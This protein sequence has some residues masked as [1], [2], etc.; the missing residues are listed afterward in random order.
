MTGEVRGMPTTP[1]LLG[2][3]AGSAI[4]R[5]LGEELRRTRE[6][7]GWSRGHLVRQLPSGIGDRTL[8]S[9]E[10]GARQ[11][12]VLRL[13]ELAQTLGVPASVLVSDALQRARLHLHNVV[14][15][16]DLRQLLQDDNINY[17][18][19]FQWARNRLNESRD[20]VVEVTPSGVR[21][22]AAFLGRTP[23]EMST[24]LAAF[25]PDLGEDGDGPP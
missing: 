3:T 22:L 10:H 25:A 9:Y 21:E 11:I 5:A 17:R 8:L 14:L 20:G 1:G 4:A 16:V 13:I 6:A 2:E 7:R 12:S 24:Y 18:P 15:R 19:M 23:A